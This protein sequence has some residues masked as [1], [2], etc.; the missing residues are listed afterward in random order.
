MRR[1]S[2][3]IGSAARSLNSAVRSRLA[4][5]STASAV[6]AFG[7]DNPLSFGGKTAS[8]QWAK[9]KSKKGSVSKTK[10]VPRLMRPRTYEISRASGSVI[11]YNSND[12]DDLF[13]GS[14]G[15]KSPESNFRTLKRRLSRTMTSSGWVLICQNSVLK[16]NNHQMQL[17]TISQFFRLKD[18]LEQYI[19][20]SKTHT[21]NAKTFSKKLLEK[22]ASATP[23]QITQLIQRQHSAC[24]KIQIPKQGETFLRQVFK[25]YSTEVDI[26][27]TKHTLVDVAN[28]R[29]VSSYFWFIHPA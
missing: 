24:E 2:I 1:N 25:R 4:P 16:L 12:D 9:A 13:V 7:N 3:D 28:L 10:I 23:T 20:R 19:E 27:G 11:E 18:S 29:N 17:F 15:P 6:K 14:L 5:R 26:K 8:N 22:W 21:E